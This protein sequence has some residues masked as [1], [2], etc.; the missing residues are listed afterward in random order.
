MPRCVYSRLCINCHYCHALFT[1]QDEMR[2]CAAGRGAINLSSMHGDVLH[3]FPWWSEQV[4]KIAAR[5][6]LE[7][8]SLRKSATAHNAV[9][10][11]WTTARRI[12]VNLTGLA[13]AVPETDRLVTGLSY[14]GHQFI[15][16]CISIQW[17]SK[18]LNEHLVSTHIGSTPLI[19]TVWTLT[20]HLPAMAVH[21]NQPLP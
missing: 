7:I 5:H 10:I 3:P 21:V 16:R 17:S 12:L 14:S 15:D 11:T 8:Q 2:P 20:A 4:G 18:T 9:H 13:S 6:F 19:G 1:V